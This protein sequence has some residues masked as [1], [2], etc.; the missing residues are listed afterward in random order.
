MLCL[1]RKFGQDIHLGDTVRITVLEI[2]GDKVRLGIE[3][4][5]NVRIHRGEIYKSIERDLRRQFGEP[6]SESERG[7]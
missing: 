4:P 6:E 2:C 7:L 1:S 3:A 5:K